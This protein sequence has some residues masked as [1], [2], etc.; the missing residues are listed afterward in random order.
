MA[1]CLADAGFRTAEGM[2]R[3]FPDEVIIP[4]A[5]PRNQWTAGS[6]RISANYIPSEQFLL[7]FPDEG[8]GRRASREEV[9]AQ[10]RQA[11]SSCP[12]VFSEANQ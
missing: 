6:G 3:R 4:R 5:P 11:L 7:V 10:A 2:G 1:D 9:L 8:R 12:L